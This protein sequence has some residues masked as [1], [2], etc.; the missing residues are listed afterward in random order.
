[1]N[2][3]SRAA[4]YALIGVQEVGESD[5]LEAVVRSSRLHAGGSWPLNLS[6]TSETE[7]FLDAGRTR[8]GGNP[9]PAKLLMSK[10]RSFC[11]ISHVA[12]S[13][14]LMAGSVVIGN[15]RRRAERVVSCIL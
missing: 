3:S 10:L 6:Q 9:R 4:V 13:A 2:S 5:L 7:S 8:V 12:I 14:T 15:R 1:M 11:D